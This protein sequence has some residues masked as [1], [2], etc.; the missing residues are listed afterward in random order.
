MENNVNIVNKVLR[1]F[2]FS[3]FKETVIATYDYLFMT[4]LLYLLYLLY[5]NYR[6]VLYFEDYIYLLIV[7][8]STTLII[9]II[10]LIYAYNFSHNYY[11]AV[12]RVISDT[13]YRSKW[14]KQLLDSAEDINLAH[15]I[16]IKQYCEITDEQYEVF[17]KLY[18]NGA[19]NIRYLE[20]RHLFD[21]REILDINNYFDGIKKK[22]LNNQYAVT[23]KGLDSLVQIGALTD[24]EAKIKRINTRSSLYIR[25]V[26]FFGLLFIL[27]YL[28][29]IGFIT[30][31][32]VY[33]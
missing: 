14:L 1:N 11:R 8:L 21:I 6:Y 32:E 16:L 22:F 28:P 25:T 9:R 7:F 13:S 15:L 23:Q 27:F 12:D 24:Y 19:T 4:C 18:A 33:L 5:A 10:N 30:L 17:K 3:P 29:I 26:S 20:F 31:L 2:I